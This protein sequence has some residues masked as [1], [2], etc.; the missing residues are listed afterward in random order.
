[1]ER[2]VGSTEVVL[3]TTERIEQVRSR[4][5][6]AQSRQKSYADKR[7]LDQE[8]QIGEFVIGD[9]VLLKV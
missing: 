5:Q 4:L 1:M 6:I 2:V 8:F 7:H 9:M 3:K